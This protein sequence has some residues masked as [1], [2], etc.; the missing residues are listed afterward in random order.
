[1]KLGVSHKG[2]FQISLGIH[3]L[4]ENW[5]DGMI[6]FPASQS[7]KAKQL[8]EYLQGR[9]GYAQSTLRRLIMLGDMQSLSDKEL[10]SCLDPSAKEEKEPAA[11]LVSDQFNS[12][13]DRR[14][15][16]GTANVYRETLT[17]IS[18]YH[19]LDKLKFEDITVA[20]LK[21]FESRLRRDGLAVNSVARHLRDIRAVY[22]DAIDYNI[23][24]LA[25]YPFRRFKI[26]HEATAKR[27]LTLEQLRQL[28]DY[29][30]E[31][32]HEKYRDLFM[33]IFYLGGINLVDLLH[34][35]EITNGRIEYRRAKTSALYSI[36]VEPEAQEIIDKYKGVNQLLFPLDRYANYKDFLHRMNRNLREM[37]TAEIVP[38][39]NGRLGKKE[40]TGLFPGLSSYWS[41][42]TLA[43]LMAEI[44]IPMETIGKV[45]GHSDSKSVTAIYVK[46][47]QKKIDR[48][49]RDV[50][51]YVNEA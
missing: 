23:I 26:T 50:I 29:P 16:P 40:K 43:T 34:I 11:I 30:C 38:R 5:I 20:W 2:Y 22:N 46:F 8:N 35:K 39:K 4:P 37:G 17:K 31:P 6:V 19:D 12:F 48:A 44:D 36:K 49:M 42:H 15:K 41:R 33:L 13:I 32:H 45:L 24:S 27:S 14:N 1:V 21:D 25:S 7:A 9:L 3:V 10:R 28:R 18:K 51:D 47:D